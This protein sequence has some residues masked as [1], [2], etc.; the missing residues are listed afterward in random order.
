MT[1]TPDTWLIAYSTGLVTSASTASGA[2]PGYCVMT[3]TKGRLVSGICSTRSRVY[4][5][6]PSTM[7]ATM[8]MVANTGL[9]IETRVIHMDF[10]RLGSIVRLAAVWRERRMV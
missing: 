6:T 2:A 8:N 3:S 10:R 7:I 5:N 1:F 4:E 9:L